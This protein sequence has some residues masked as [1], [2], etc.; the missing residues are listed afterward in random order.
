[1]IEDD[2]GYLETFDEQTK[3]FIFNQPYNRDATT[4]NCERVFGWYDIYNKI[5]ELEK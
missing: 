5:R 3:V 2:P 1:M 4:P